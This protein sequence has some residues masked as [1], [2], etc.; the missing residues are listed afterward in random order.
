[1]KYEYSVKTARQHASG[2]K[3]HGW[4]ID[5]HEEALL[6]EMGILGWELCAIAGLEP[7][8]RKYFFKRQ[9]D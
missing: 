7:S 6:M 2:G 8:T 4:T 1:M 5:D 3:E 9:K